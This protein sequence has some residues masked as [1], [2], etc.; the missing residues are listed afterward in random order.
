MPAAAERMKLL[1]RLTR[2]MADT[3]TL[4]DLGD[5]ALILNRWAA[6][7]LDPDAFRR[8]VADLGTRLKLA[9]TAALEADD[10][11]LRDQLDRIRAPATALVSRLAEALREPLDRLPSGALSIVGQAVRRPA[12]EAWLL[13]RRGV[14]ADICRFE[15]ELQYARSTGQ[16][17]LATRLTAYVDML[18]GDLLEEIS[19]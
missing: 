19:P 9:T 12:P 6:W 16:E 3:E 5:D 8:L 10:A 2:T 4:L 7:E 13:A 11:G 1:H 18:A 14:I 17:E 15:T